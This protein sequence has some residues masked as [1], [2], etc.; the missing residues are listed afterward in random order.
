MDH[1]SFIWLSKRLA[2]CISG[3]FIVIESVNSLQDGI[4]LN[5]IKYMQEGDQLVGNLIATLTVR[6]IPECS[7]R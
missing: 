3:I 5:G 1:L 7:L 2:L 6:S 4:S